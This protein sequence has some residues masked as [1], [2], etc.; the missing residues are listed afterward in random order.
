MIRGA[1][2]YI[3][4]V[5]RRGY[6]FLAPI[7]PPT[8]KLHPDGCG[9]CCRAKVFV[10]DGSVDSLLSS[11]CRAFGLRNLV[12][13]LPPCRI[14]LKC[15]QSRSAHLLFPTRQRDQPFRQTEL[16]GVASC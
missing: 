3:E 12:L 11:G 9:P 13:C 6:R 14:E 4:T 10:A 7:D 15:A 8:W 16:C 5:A 2:K 1:S